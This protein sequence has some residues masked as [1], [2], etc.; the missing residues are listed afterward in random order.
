VPCV[1]ATLQ[2][3][4]AR[5]EPHLHAGILRATRWRAAGRPQARCC[6]S[7]ADEPARPLP[8]HVVRVAARRRAA[9]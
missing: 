9:R 2:R 3:Q 6:Q 5:A 7:V 8:Q 1:S 4:R